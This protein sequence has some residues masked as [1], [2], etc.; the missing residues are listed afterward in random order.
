MS[1]LSLLSDALSDTTGSLA[2]L[3]ALDGLRRGGAAA[4]RLLSRGPRATEGATTPLTE[5]TPVPRLYTL[6]S[7]TGPDGHPLQRVSTQPPGTYAVFYVDGSPRRFLLTETLLRDGSFGAER[8]D[9]L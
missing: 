5:G 9:Y 3:L 2:A 1:L 8:A 4:R 7:T 6:Y